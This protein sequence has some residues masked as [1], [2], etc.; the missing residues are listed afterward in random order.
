M[1]YDITNKTIWIAGSTGMVGQAL[2]KRLE[3]ENCRILTTTRQDLDCTRQNEVEEWMTANRLD[4]VVISAARVGGIMANQNEPAQFIFENLA[5]AQNIIHSSWLNSIEKLLFLGSSCI[6]PKFSEIPIKEESLLSGTLEK[7]NEP[8]AIAKIAGIKLCQAY[9]RQYGCRFISVMPCNLYGPGDLYDDARSHVIP[10]L[11]QRFHKAKINRSTEVTIWGTGNPRREFLYIDD[12][13]DALVFLLKNYED[14]IQ[15]NVGTGE[16]IP[17]LELAHTIANIVGFKG[18]IKTDPSRPDG[19]YRKV[20]D[21]G[22]LKNMGWKP[23][24]SLEQGLSQTYDS[25]LRI[26]SRYKD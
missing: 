21:N 22:R 14:E 6:Y 9:M 4:A 2:V 3:T 11:I 24:I 20:M 16:D 18:E 10:A 1:T 8:Y 12:L 15:I 26:M 19:T 13:A 23:Q 17:I 5:I 7:T 25:F